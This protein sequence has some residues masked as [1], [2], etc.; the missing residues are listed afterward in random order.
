[1]EPFHVSVTAQICH[2]RDAVHTIVEVFTKYLK[3]KNN[4][5]SLLLHHL[6]ILLF[7]IIIML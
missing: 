4:Q 3:K 5:L 6:D 2:T 7:I 1:M